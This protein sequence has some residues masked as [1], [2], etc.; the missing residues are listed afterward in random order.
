MRKLLT[1][2]AAA[3]LVLLAAAAFANGTPSTSTPTP[4]FTPTQTFTPTPTVPATPNTTFT[5]DTINGSHFVTLDLDSEASLV[6]PPNQTLKPNTCKLYVAAWR[7]FL[8]C[9]DGVQHMIVFV[10]D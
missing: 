6:D 2:A 10:D 8:V 5:P 4:T 9:A 7:L 1:A 3:S